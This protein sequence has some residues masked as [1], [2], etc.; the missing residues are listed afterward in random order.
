MSL[1]VSLHELYRTSK[2]VTYQCDLTNRIVLNFA[3]QVMAFRM[4]DFVLFRRKAE[5]VNLH[6]M[7]FNL[8]DEYD[9]EV[10]E[11]PKSDQ[12]LVLTLCDLVQLRDLLA[13]TQFTLNLNSMLH[14]VLYTYSY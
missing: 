9:F 13:G 12:K 4:A 14:E 3:D 11:A 2:G 1:N 5:R 7:I 8:D 10:L 6:E